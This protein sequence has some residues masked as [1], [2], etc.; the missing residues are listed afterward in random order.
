MRL[1]ESSIVS[2]IF[3]ISALCF[4]AVLVELAEASTDMGA[5][6]GT[7]FPTSTPC[8]DK[9]LLVS[10][11]SCESISGCIVPC[12]SDMTASAEKDPMPEFCSRRCQGL[13]TSAKRG[14]WP[15]GF[16]GYPKGPK[17]PIIRYSGLG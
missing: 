2:R 15:S 3:S 12:S 5:V 9:R 11:L 8:L 13:P 16:R 17:D 7:A 1:F 6:P 4:W 14:W 10:P